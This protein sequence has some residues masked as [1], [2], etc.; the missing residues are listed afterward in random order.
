MLRLSRTTFY[1]ATAGTAYAA[2]QIPG[3]NPTLDL[4]L[5]LAAAVAIA[6][7]GHAAIDCPPNC[8]GTDAQKRPRTIIPILYLPLIAI[9]AI[10]LIL[11]MMTGCT[12]P[13]PAAVAG[14]TNA[15]AYV[16]NPQI[17]VWSNTITPIATTAGTVTGTGVLIPTTTNAA[18]L[19]LA[20]LSGLWAKHKSDSLA[21]LAAGVATTG[22]TTTAA[23][24]AATADSPKFA[25][26]AGALN[27]QL[28]AGQ[29]PGGEAPVTPTLTAS[30]PPPK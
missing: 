23:V 28:A 5:K 2:A 22:P 29:A 30:P 10:A 11:S 3:V 26:I 7:L 25:T 27:S 19:L 1:G 14:A 13:N 16:V 6:A 17:A 15:P 9:C 18:F 8:P 12:T 4:T 21:A 20:A 24:L